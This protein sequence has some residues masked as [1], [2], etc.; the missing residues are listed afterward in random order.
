MDTYYWVNNNGRDWA[1]FYH[2]VNLP[3]GEHIV[4][5]VVKNEKNP[6]ATNTYITLHEAV[7]YG[8]E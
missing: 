5:I 4:R 7:V 2:N 6:N 3:N 8:L 1:H